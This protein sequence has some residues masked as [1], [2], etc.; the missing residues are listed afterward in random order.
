MRIVLFWYNALLNQKGWMEFSGEGLWLFMLMEFEDIN[1]KTKNFQGEGG[2]NTKGPRASCIVLPPTPS[3]LN[4]YW[5]IAV[6]YPTKV[7][8]AGRFGEENHGVRVRGG[9]LVLKGLLHGHLAALLL[10]GL[11]FLSFVLVGQS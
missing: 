1:C 2:G 8:S 10:H 5:K 7:G 4:L 6:I 9:V 11:L 3:S